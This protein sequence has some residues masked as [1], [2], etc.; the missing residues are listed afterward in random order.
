MSRASWGRVVVAVVLGYIA[1]TVLVIAGE[2]LLPLLTSGTGGSSHYY[3][4][5][6]VGQSLCTIAAGYLCCVVAGLAEWRAMVGLMVL[7]L[8]IGSAFLA[9]SWSAEPHWYVVGLLLVFPPCVWVGWI[10]RQKTIR[11][12]HVGQ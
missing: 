8:L 4:I 7:G 3:T 9:R 6:L 1:N 5:D 12:F 2:L 11:Q 10:I